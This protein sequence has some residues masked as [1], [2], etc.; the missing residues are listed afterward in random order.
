M[1]KHGRRLDRSKGGSLG[2]RVVRVA[3]ATS[4]GALSALLASTGCASKKDGGTVYVDGGVGDP[5]KGGLAIDGGCEAKCSPDKCLPGNTCVGNRCELLCTSHR[6]CFSDGSQN[7][8]A[9][10]DDS[11]KDVLVCQSSKQ[12]P[13][14]GV[15]CP[16][17][18]ECNKQSFC[19]GGVACD[20]AACGGHPDHCKADPAQC[21]GNPKCT[22][23]K[24]SDDASECIVTTCDAAQC[25]APSYRCL[26][27]G[28]GDA[29]AYCAKDD[30][31][32]D[33]DCLGG[34]YCGITRDPHSICG[35]TPPKGNSNACGKTTEPCVD[36]AHFADGGHTYFEGALCLMRR[37][38]LKRSQCAPCKTDLDCSQR[39]A[40]KCVAIGAESHCARSCG[41]DSDCEPDAKCTAGSC[42]PRAGACK[43]KGAFC[44]PC[45]NDEDC[46]TKGT[47]LEC[48]RLAG[49]MRACF[50]AAF[51]IDCT[52]DTDCP[53]APSGL[54]GTC[55][56]E[57]ASLS[58]GDS[59]YHKCYL[60]MNFDTNKTSCW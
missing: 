57:R 9:A 16:F 47:R 52:V 14:I 30:C 3:L 50:D 18:T 28:T 1:A 55:L 49:T 19:P 41:G 42:I 17:G 8:G 44:D 48:A 32:T 38:C 7:C 51:A 22:I 11:G 5:C 4:L 31:K 59:V 56:D 33:D 40:Q 6:D 25:A 23:G 34:Y 27:T 37:T 20:P 12:T 46:G 60:P 24:C 26:T 15:K 29:D 2:G 45:L 43:G 10:K 58:P 35:L 21:A 36:P 39:D 54:N 13:G 53:K